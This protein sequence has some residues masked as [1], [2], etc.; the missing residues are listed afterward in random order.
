MAQTI[1]ITAK[2]SVE[3]AH[4][5]CFLRKYNKTAKA[6]EN[7]GIVLLNKEAVAEVM[8]RIGEEV[9]EN[10]K[11]EYSFNLALERLI[12]EEQHDE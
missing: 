1:E 12:M 10:L 3:T 5:L 7:E 6:A 9:T 8:K 2:I 4:V 11:N